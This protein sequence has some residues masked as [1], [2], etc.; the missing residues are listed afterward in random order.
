MWKNLVIHLPLKLNQ[1]SAIITIIN[2]P[3]LKL[4]N[5]HIIG[6]DTLNNKLKDNIFFQTKK[7]IYKN[8]TTLY[9]LLFDAL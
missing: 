7:K 6:E 5:I 9:P 1:S 8:K 2:Y 4:K 3:F